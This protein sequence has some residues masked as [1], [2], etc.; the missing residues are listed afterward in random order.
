MNNLELVNSV[1]TLIAGYSLVVFSDFTD[2]GEARYRY[3]WSLILLVIILC[4][5]NIGVQIK[6]NTR[7]SIKAGKKKFKNKKD[8]MTKEYLTK[9][10]EEKKIRK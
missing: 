2:S 9:T 5:L 1:I 10:R 6:T 3:A 7:K 4:I 8:K